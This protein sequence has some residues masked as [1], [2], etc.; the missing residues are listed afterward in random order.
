MD[1]DDEVDEVGSH[2]PLKLGLHVHE[3]GGSCSDGLN[4]MDV[5]LGESQRFK[6]TPLT[7]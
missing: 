5:S 3:V 4:H 7:S 2:E 6:V 1:F